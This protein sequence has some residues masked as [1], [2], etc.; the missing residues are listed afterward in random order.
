MPVKHFRFMPA[1]GE[2]SLKAELMIYDFRSEPW[3]TPL[4]QGL[5]RDRSLRVRLMID[6]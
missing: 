6:Y 3:A 5:R 1:L 2:V 4:R